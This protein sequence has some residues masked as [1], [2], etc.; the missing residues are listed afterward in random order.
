M[1][2]ELNTNLSKDLGYESPIANVLSIS[3]E[4]VIC[5]SPNFTIP[6]WTENNDAL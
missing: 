4:G 6:D 1:N 5:T 2:K 3:T